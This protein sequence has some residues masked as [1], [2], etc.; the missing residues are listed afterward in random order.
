MLAAE[1]Q[2]GEGGKEHHDSGVHDVAAIAPTV[3]RNEMHETG[4]DR[5]AMNRLTCT[6]SFIELLYD[7]S[8]D[9]PAEDIRDECADA[10]HSRREQRR[11]AHKPGDRRSR[12]LAAEVRHRGSTP[13]D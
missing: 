9:K 13:S 12:K 11:P 5:L 7:R 3:S 8:G 2:T 1:R 4:D 10:A 6:N